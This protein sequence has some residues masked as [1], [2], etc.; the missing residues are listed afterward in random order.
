MLPTIHTIADSILLRKS[1]K[2][3]DCPAAEKM[4]LDCKSLYN[5]FELFLNKTL[6][7]LIHKKHKSKSTQNY[8]TNLVCIKE[9]LDAHPWCIPCNLNKQE[10]KTFLMDLDFYL[11]LSGILIKA[12][13]MFKGFLCGAQIPSCVRILPKF[14]SNPKKVQQVYN[15]L[16]SS[17]WRISIE[18]YYLQNK[19]LKL[20]Y[21]NEKLCESISAE[22]ILAKPIK[23]LNEAFNTLPTNF[24]HEKYLNHHLK[25]INNLLKRLNDNQ[26]EEDVWLEYR[27]LISEPIVLGLGS[28]ELCRLYMQQLNQQYNLSGNSINSE[29]GFIKNQLCRSKML[30]KDKIIKTNNGINFLNDLKSQIHKLTDLSPDMPF[31]EWNHNPKDF[32]KSLQ[33]IISK[34]YLTIKGNNDLQPIMQVISRFVKVKKQ[35]NTGNLSYSTLL[36]YLRKANTG[37]L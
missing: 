33:Q 7:D 14:S 16:K 29:I 22:H 13:R 25:D 15:Q 20:I 37:E 11:M 32:I 30:F 23:L 18:N 8:L 26:E 4:P 34:G 17:P 27:Q 9:T 1:L 24:E 12:R 19:Y 36:T 2:W 10:H 21:E 5:R 6:P 31:I 3:K 28:K 35:N